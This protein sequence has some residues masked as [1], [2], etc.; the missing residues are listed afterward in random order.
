MRAAGIVFAAAMALGL[1]A[2]DVREV[3]IRVGPYAFPG[4]TI[5][6]QA[7]LVETGVTVRDRRGNPVGGFTASDFEV[8]DNGKPQE[9]TFFSEQNAAKTLTSG[10]QEGQGKSLGHAE[11]PAPPLPP[12][13][14]R[15]LALFFDDTH[16][17]SFDCHK[18]VL[19]AEKVL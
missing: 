17:S 9:I 18:V 5:S 15:S 12:T 4:T 10:Q 13:A 7:N 6:V 11:A 1:H 16:A 14:P 2:E 19:A 3:R 8:F